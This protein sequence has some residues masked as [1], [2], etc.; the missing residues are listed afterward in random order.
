[1]PVAIRNKLCEA[2]GILAEQDVSRI[3]SQ[4]TKANKVAVA[5]IRYL[6]KRR[7]L[8]LRLLE[9]TGCRPGELAEMSVSKNNQCTKTN[10]LILPTL[11]RRK[12]VDPE[13]SVPVIPPYSGE[14]IRRIC[15]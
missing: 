1:M 15:C 7:Q 4:T 13:R 3:E 14:I 2:V 12:L 11:K 8:L 5:E 6:T 9:T 10:R